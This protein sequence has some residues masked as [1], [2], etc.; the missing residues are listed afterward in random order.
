VPKW[1]APLTPASTLGALL[2]PALLFAAPSSEV[3]LARIWGLGVRRV[4]KFTVS[5]SIL[6]Q[7]SA[8]DGLTAMDNWVLE[9][10]RKALD[11]SLSSVG[12]GLSRWLSV[13]WLRR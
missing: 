11:Q 2:I 9:Q 10:R 13:F 1:G 7:S 3:S 8:D 5:V 12:I 6:P 4:E